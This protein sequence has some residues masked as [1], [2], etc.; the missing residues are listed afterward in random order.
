MD[1]IKTIF[2]HLNMLNQYQADHSSLHRSH[3]RN[4]YSLHF[5]VQEVRELAVKSQEHVNQPLL[6]NTS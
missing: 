5:F 3:S 4:K 6:V 2:R 1:A